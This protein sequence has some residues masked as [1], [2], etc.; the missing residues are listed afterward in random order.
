MPEPVE[1]EP[2]EPRRSGSLG[3]GLPHGDIG[4]RACR[5]HSEDVGRAIAPERFQLA[6]QASRVWGIPDLLPLGLF[7]APQVLE[8]VADMDQAPTGIKILPK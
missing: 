3:H 4:Q 7:R 6:L 5:G 8:I 1:G 2:R